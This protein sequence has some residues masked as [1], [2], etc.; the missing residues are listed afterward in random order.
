MSALHFLVGYELQLLIDK[1]GTKALAAA[2]Y[3]AQKVNFS[4]IS[5]NK[6]LTIL[7]R[8]LDLSQNQLASEDE[9]DENLDL[10]RS[11]RSR[12]TQVRMRRSSTSRKRSRAQR[13]FL[14]SHSQSFRDLES[15]VVAL[16]TLEYWKE[17]E[18]EAIL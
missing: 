8:A 9:Y 7:G 11:T 4:A 13:G 10:R 6:T 1:L 18:A 2:R 5:V 12:S 16:D 15:L 17:K 14:L 3:L